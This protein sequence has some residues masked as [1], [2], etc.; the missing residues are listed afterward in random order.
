MSQ[1]VVDLS[2]VIRL[3]QAFLLEHNLVGAARTLEL[4]S[5]CKPWCDNEVS[6]VVWRF[7][8]DCSHFTLTDLNP[9]FF[10]AGGCICARSDPRRQM[11]GSGGIPHATCVFALL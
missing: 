5:G 6:A 7:G 9:P 2:S 4:E 3:V 1:V 10:R 11:V 8:V